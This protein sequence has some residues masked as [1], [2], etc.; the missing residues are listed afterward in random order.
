MFRNTWVITTGV[1]LCCKYKCEPPVELIRKYLVEL[2]FAES[3]MDIDLNM[4][5]NFNIRC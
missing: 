3:K 2:G 4:H 5:E 1:L